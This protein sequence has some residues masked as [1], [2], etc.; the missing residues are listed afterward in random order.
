MMAMEAASRSS[1]PNRLAIDNVEED[2]ELRAA[3]K[4]SSSGSRQQ[5]A[6]ID[7][8]ADADKQQQ[9]E[10]VRHARLK[11]GFQHF[12]RAGV[13]QVAGMQPKPIGSSSVGPS[14]AD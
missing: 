13:R 2:A 3:P 12:H 7:H 14:L 8:R 1:K 5:R 6:E 11:Q 9:R 4:S 10:S